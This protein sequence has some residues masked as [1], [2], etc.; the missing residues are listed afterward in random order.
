MGGADHICL[1]VAGVCNQDM[2]CVSGRC[3]GKDGDAG[4]SD[5][6]CVVP[7][8][9]SRGH[10]TLVPELV[11][12]S[13]VGAQPAAGPGRRLSSGRLSSGS[14]GALASQAWSLAWSLASS[15]W[16]RWRPGGPVGPS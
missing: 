6:K 3:V 8:L 10:D 16:M 5:K 9:V 13:Q 7:E 15:A 11:S 1:K 14:F 4:D 2:E 12:S